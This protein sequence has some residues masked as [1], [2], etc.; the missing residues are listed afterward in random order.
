MA[1]EVIDN[2]VSAPRERPSRS[3][4]YSVTVEYELHLGVGIQPASVA[5]ILGDCYL[6]LAGDTH[7]K[8]LT[9]DS[10][11]IQVPHMILCYGVTELRLRR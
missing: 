10:Y 2:R 4:P 1:A 6:P 5:Q 8:N 7:G 11:F 9:S 3:D